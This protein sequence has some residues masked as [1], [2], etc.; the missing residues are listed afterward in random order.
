MLASCSAVSTDRNVH[1]N[2]VLTNAQ[3]GTLLDSLQHN[4]HWKRPAGAATSLSFGGKSR[5]LCIGDASGAVCLWDLKK[6]VRARQFF[7]DGQP[8][9][10]VSLDPTDTFVLSLSPRNLRSYKVREGVAAS[11]WAT[12][13]GYEFTKYS[14]S[15]LEPHLVAVGTND[16]SMR[17]YDI[18]NPHESEAVFTLDRRHNS[19][20]TG[21]AFSYTNDKLLASTS[22]EGSLQFFDK[23]SGALIEELARLTS[24]ISSLAL[25]SDGFSCAVGTESGEI[26]IY[27]LRRTGSAVASIIVSGEVRGL[28][29]SPPP[30]SKT[31]AGKTSPSSLNRVVGSTPTASGTS[32][33]KI[34]ESTT[35]SQQRQSNGGL[36]PS[37]NS[38]EPVTTYQG[39]LDD[40]A[41][42]TNRISNASSRPIGSPQKSRGDYGYAGVVQN[43][44]AA[45]GV[46]DVR[47][48][49]RDEVE[50]LQ[51][52]LE[53]SLRNLH[54]DMIRQFHQ[55]S[56]ELNSA[57]SSQ[58]AA[59]DQLR[60]ENQ[61]L[62]EENDFLKR[63]HDAQQQQHQHDHGRGSVGQPMNNGSEKLFGR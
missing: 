50:K 60:E 37:V 52:D 19:P 8:A 10:Q 29:F 48:I 15:T 61:R 11:T 38:E 44:V 34:V 24:G 13:G 4:Q 41:G 59:M 12:R 36:V 57:L 21:M 47:N 35:I 1:N 63:H 51:D 5:Y 2:I 62:R 43:S 17:L 55:Q 3:T 28:R 30:K 22:R 54:T 58:L 33:P 49:V 23:G 14:S 6:K 45:I 25:C 53:E 27:D 26:L 39:P 16:G 9:L 31:S 56:E 20:I 40:L 46:D 18:T 32:I 7:H 42:P